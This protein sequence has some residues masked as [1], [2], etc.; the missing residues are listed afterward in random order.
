V[1]PLTYQRINLADH[2]TLGDWTVAEATPL[3][4][5]GSATPL[6][7]SPPAAG[8][9]IDGAWAGSVIVTQSLGSIVLLAR[10]TD[11]AGPGGVSDPFQL[12][13]RDADGDGAPDFWETQNGFDPADAADA[14]LDADG[15]GLTNLQEYLAG[16]DPRNR[17]SV[18][19]ITESILEPM[20]IR[21]RFR[22]VAGRRYRLEGTGSITG[23]WGGI[24]E[25][26]GTGGLLEMTATR[27]PAARRF[28]RIRALP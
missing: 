6:A 16:T 28:Y 19:Q 23:S 26:N 25:T 17:A 3:T 7:I 4:I 12:I 24:S 9:F 8:P 14:A 22:T 15:D 2:N 27:T 10:A 11:D 1:F 21:I 13:A 20:K 5:L 18:L